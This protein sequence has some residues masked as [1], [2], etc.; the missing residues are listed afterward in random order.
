MSEDLLRDLIILGSTEKQEIECESI[1]ELINLRQRIYGKKK[2]LLKP[3]SLDLHGKKAASSFE[4]K[5][6]D[7]DHDPIVFNSQYY[8][9]QVEDGLKFNPCYLILQ[10]VLNDLRG[11]IE[12]SLAKHIR[13]ETLPS[14]IEARRAEA[15]FKAFA[16][17]SRAISEAMGSEQ[18]KPTT[19][20]DIMRKLQSKPKE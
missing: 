17:E 2:Q 14:Q 18:P 19:P 8:K 3:G 16:N 7:C 20:F 9:V 11:T 4:L 6:Q 15:D 12:K 5:M 10:P 13:D 1:K